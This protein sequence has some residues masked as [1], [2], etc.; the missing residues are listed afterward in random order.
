MSIFFIK[1]YFVKICKA[2]LMGYSWRVSRSTLLDFWSPV[3]AAHGGNVIWCYRNMVKGTV[4][5]GRQK[6]GWRWRLWPSIIML[7]LKL[8]EWVAPWR[9][10]SFRGK[11]WWQRW[12]IWWKAVEASTSTVASEGTMT[13]RLL[14]VLLHLQP[15]VLLDI[16]GMGA[17]SYS[18]YTS[19]LLL[20]F[21]LGR[22]GILWTNL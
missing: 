18:I 15:P 22:T 17:S 10:W 8:L 3:R 21:M 4:I 20:F 13:G 11:W 1:L 7:L 14:A 6:R 5:V 16:I 2:V 12:P 19:D 9:T